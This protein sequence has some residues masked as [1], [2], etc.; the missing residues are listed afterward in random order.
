[1][2]EPVIVC[3]VSSSL[4]WIHLEPLSVVSVIDLVYYEDGTELDVV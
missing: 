1:M 3:V 4:K 2:P